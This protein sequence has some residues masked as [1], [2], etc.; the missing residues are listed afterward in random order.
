MGGVTMITIKLRINRGIFNLLSSFLEY[1][2]P[3]IIVEDLASLCAKESLMALM[4]KF[5]R[6]K[7]EP[8][9][10][11]TFRLSLTTANSLCGILYAMRKVGNYEDIVACELLRDIQQQI[12]RHVRIRKNDKTL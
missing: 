10:S 3:Y 8:R 4:Q 12:D 1:S 11:Y 2:I 5:N 9:K 7:Y 6:L